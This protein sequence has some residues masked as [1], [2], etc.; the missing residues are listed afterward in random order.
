MLPTRILLISLASALIFSIHASGTTIDV[1][2]IIDAGN[3]LNDIIVVDGVSPPTHLSIV[4]GGVASIANSGLAIDAFGSSR[5]NLLGGRIQSGFVGVRLNDNARL[6]VVDGEIATSGYIAEAHDRGRIRIDAGSF[7]G[8]SQL[9][10]SGLLE[11][12]GGDI[13]ATRGFNSAK[14]VQR[15]GSLE[16]LFLNDDSTFVMHD[17]GIGFT[18]ETNGNSRALIN[19]GTIGGLALAVLNDESVLT[20]RGGPQIAEFR[21][22]DEALLHVYGFG[23]EF[24]FDEDLGHFV[25][26]TLA[27]GSVADFRYRLADQDQIILHEVPEPATWGILLVGLAGL[28]AARRYK[29]CAATR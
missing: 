28:L 13:R 6:H 16:D 1:D 17:G 3:P 8:G 27:D 12:N 11:M 2:T 22:N 15:G 21:V 5:V 20:L 29:L 4:A 18:L 23:L 25:Q 7:V 24:V 19:G 10:D 26:G 14:I 9:F